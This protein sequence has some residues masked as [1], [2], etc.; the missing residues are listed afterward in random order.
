MNTKLSGKINN[1]ANRI[2]SANCHGD[3]SDQATCPPAPGLRGPEVMELSHDYTCGQLPPSSP[4]AAVKKGGC[5]LGCPDR[6]LPQPH[7]HVCAVPGQ[8]LLPVPGGPR[9]TLRKGARA[10]QGRRRLLPW[11]VQ[12]TAR[13][14]GARET[15]KPPPRDGPRGEPS[16]Q[17]Q[18]LDLL[19]SHSKTHSF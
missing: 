13:G 18:A 15:L 2:Y 10:Q 3:V 1:S 5:G 16:P 14:M 8:E 11:Q 12:K 17:P 4:G 7:C 9:G 6:S 19:G